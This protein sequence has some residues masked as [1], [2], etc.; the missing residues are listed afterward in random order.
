MIQPALDEFLE[1]LAQIA[2]DAASDDA[3]S[4]ISAFFARHGFD[5]LIYIDLKP[6]RLMLRSTLPDAWIA[7]YHAQ[8]YAQID[9]FFSHCGTT[10][11][12]ISTGAAYLDQHGML[13]PEQKNLI[14]EAAEFGINAG[15]S[16]TVQIMGHSGF[17]GWNIG[18]SLSRREVDGLRA[19]REAALRL[20]ARHAHDVLVQTSALADRKLLSRRELECMM[21]LAQGQRNK[22]I[23]RSLSISTAAVELYLR[24]ARRK[25]GATTREQSVATAAA[26]GL[27]SV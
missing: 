5:K 6:D 7:R 2:S 18:S 3:W 21:L 24:N 17:A 23:A 13:S 10:Y 26:R 16:S 22:D 27:L 25:L 11:R 1:G 4:F 15:F 20:A 19:D 12:P 8:G 14:S 9:P